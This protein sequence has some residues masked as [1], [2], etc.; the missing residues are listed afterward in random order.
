MLWKTKLNQPVWKS[1][2][3]I[4]NCFQWHRSYFEVFINLGPIC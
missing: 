1:G 2:A 4:G 3:N